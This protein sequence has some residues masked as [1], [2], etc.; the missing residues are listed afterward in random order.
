MKLV[1]YSF[2]LTLLFPLLALGQNRWEREMSRD[3]AEL[4]EQINSM[5]KDFETRLNDVKNAADKASDMA[6][7]ANMAVAQI[8]GAV[9]NRLR[10]Q[11]KLV[12]VPILSMGTRVD[13]MSTELQ[14]VRES[15]TGLSGQLTKLQTQLVDVSNAI[16]TLS[17]PPPPPGGAAAAAL[18]SSS[19]GPPTGVSAD[20]IYQNALRDR[21]SGKLDMA[22]TGF[23]DYLK[24]FPA[25]DYAPNAQYYIGDILYARGDY[26][27][28]LQ[29][30][31]LVL[32]KYP[33]NPKTPDARYMKAQALLKLNQRN[34]AVQE[35]REL[36]RT[37]PNSDLASKANSEL[38][39][40]GINPPVTQKKKR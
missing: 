8:D 12:Q 16:R 37:S 7:K 6:F 13:Q 17:A 1:R 19:A 33:T 22:M 25:T 32:E 31:D 34:G 28:A 2:F 5:R 14:A 11:E 26:N 39:R 15:I 36:I 27:N 29:A 10:E 3:I 23:Q 4:K 18:G 30:F 35:L 24:W 20:S 21:S 9:Q 38:R 40:M